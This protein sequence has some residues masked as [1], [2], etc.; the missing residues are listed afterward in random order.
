VS[1]ER[2]DCHLSL[3]LPETGVWW[4]PDLDDEPNGVRVVVRQQTIS[5]SRTMPGAHCSATA[6]AISGKAWVRL[7]PWRDW[8]LTL[9]SRPHQAHLR[10][11]G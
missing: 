8:S 2:C 4:R 7:R 11:V 3:K 9:L 10:L 6:A 5:P 1:A